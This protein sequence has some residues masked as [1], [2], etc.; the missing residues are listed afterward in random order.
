[1]P[2]DVALPSVD[3]F[4]D[5]YAGGVAAKRDDA[6]NHRGSRYEIWGGVGAVLFNRITARAR[7][8]F[9]NNYFDT[10]EETALDNLI[11]QRH[12]EISP[13]VLLTAGVGTITFYR[14]AGGLLGSIFEGTRV[15]V[16]QRFFVTTETKNLSTETYVEV[17]AQAEVAGTGQSIVADV[18]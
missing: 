1:M 17:E 16:G 2:A 18:S 6:D 4:L 14:P 7:G 8:N 3:D 13:R 12:P 15:R 9:R 11:A 5:A 10:A